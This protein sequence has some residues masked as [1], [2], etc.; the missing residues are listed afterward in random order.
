MIE[1]QV[2]G[3]LTA[4]AGYADALQKVM[5]A[6]VRLGG[7]D[8]KGG[9]PNIMT[10]EALRLLREV[11]DLLDAEQPYR[12]RL[13]NFAW[14]DGSAAPSP[15]AWG[16]KDVSD[17]NAYADATRGRVTLLARNYAQPL[18]AWFTKAGTIERPDVRPLAQ[19][20]QGILD[21]LR[22]YDA[23]KPGNALAAL[24]D[25][26]GPRMAKV[27]PADCSAAGLPSGV[28][29]DTRYLG[30]TL[31]QLSQNLSRRCYE[32][33]ATS[34]LAHYNDLSNYFNQRLADRYP[35][36]DWPLRAGALEADPA[37]VRAFFRKFDADKSILSST[38]I[39]N[40]PSFAQVK[41]F[42]TDMAAVRAFFSPFL[43]ST[44]PTDFVPAFDVEAVFRTARQQEVDAD[45]IISWSMG[46]GSEEVTNRTTKPVL[47]WTFGKPVTLTLRWAANAPRVPVSA[48][49]ARAASVEDR[50]VVYRYTN[51]WSLLSALA[52]NAA[53][54]EALPHYDEEE[55]VTLGF[56]V[57][58]RRAPDG[59]Q[60][61]VP[62]QVFMRV[63]L[64][65]P[66][67]SNPMTLPHFPRIA[68]K[69]EHSIAE[70]P[71]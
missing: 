2:R 21:E 20:W 60:G 51:Q 15:A 71:Q 58:T 43:D 52:D 62:T 44:K 30:Q 32:L 37:A 67:T 6:S 65:A 12:P 16:A 45:Q 4:F 18:L 10:T 33:S 19:R 61:N 23:K 28:R 29:A 69:I 66:G 48:P 54:P 70:G 36:S 39:E 57:F 41:R 35:F 47:R 31:Q 53:P 26:I 40:D 42:L 17:V 25:Y 63:G 14:W 38:A 55:P 49:S 50:K 46:V 11:D 13:G 27:S 5:E 3:D 8:E 22:D 68:P 34:A 24:E 59:E 56:R 9:V 1:E 7:A 64:L